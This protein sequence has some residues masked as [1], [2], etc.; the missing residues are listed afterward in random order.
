M[1]PQ[2]LTVDH[3]EPSPADDPRE[4]AQGLGW[5]W[6]IVLAPLLDELNPVLEK[7]LGRTLVQSVEAILTVRDRIKGLLLSAW[8]ATWIRWAA[9]RP[10]PNAESAVACAQVGSRPQ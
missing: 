8:G 9:P 1:S 7:R 4:M 5:G 6:L 2:Y 10:E 3:A